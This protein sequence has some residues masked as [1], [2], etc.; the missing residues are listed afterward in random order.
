MTTHEYLSLI[1]AYS[2]R[3][4]ISAETMARL[5]NIASSISAP[6]TDRERVQSSRKGDKISDNI[7]KML[8]IEREDYINYSFKRK[9]IIKQIE[10]LKIQSAEILLT[11]FALCKTVEKMA[12]EKNVTAR[13]IKRLIQNAMNE[14]E[15]KFGNQYL[16]VSYQIN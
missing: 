11:R 8:D 15:A 2:R 10:S 16:D 13:H 9:E 5:E 3:M 14:F 7:A 6:P 12:D 1:K 4:E